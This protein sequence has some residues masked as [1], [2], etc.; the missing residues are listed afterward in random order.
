MSD[1]LATVTAMMKRRE[2]H[3]RGMRGRLALPHPYTGEV[4]PLAKQVPPPAY[5]TRCVT[6]ALAQ[7]ARQCPAALAAMDVGVEDVPTLTQG[8]VERVPLAA[9]VSATPTKNGQVVVFRRPIERR[10]RTRA[11]LR[12]LVYRTIV[13]Q[14]SDATGIALDE[15]D[16]SGHREDEED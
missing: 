14:L 6:D 5:F 2:R 11:G 4:V 16:P 13:E 10:A 8:W 12:I 9:A 3:G 15:I 1:R 7:I